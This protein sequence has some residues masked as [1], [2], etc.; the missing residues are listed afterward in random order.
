MKNRKAKSLAVALAALFGTGLFAGVSEA[1]TKAPVPQVENRQQAQLTLPKEQEI[2]HRAVF[3]PTTYTMNPLQSEALQPL[4]IFSGNTRKSK[5]Q[6]EKERREREK[7]E[8]ELRKKKEKEEREKRE[9]ERREREKREQ[10][11][12]RQKKCWNNDR[13]PKENFSRKPFGEHRAAVT[14][15]TSELVA[16]VD[17][18]METIEF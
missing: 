14:L 12:H 8:A 18:A 2:G 4:S 3:V 6:L 11:Q 9:R 17:Q 13:H 10:E 7:R 15:A 1:A 16:A 5:A